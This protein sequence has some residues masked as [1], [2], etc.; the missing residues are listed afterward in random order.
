MS[1]YKSAAKFR[2]RGTA[3]S[4]IKQLLSVSWWCGHQVWRRA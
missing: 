2:W 1:Q 3:F 4:S